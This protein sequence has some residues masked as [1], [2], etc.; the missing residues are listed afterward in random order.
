MRRRRLRRISVF[1][2]TAAL[3]FTTLEQALWTGSDSVAWGP[4]DVQAGGGRVVSVWGR[5]GGGGAHTQMRTHI[6]DRRAHARTPAH[7]FNGNRNFVPERECVARQYNARRLQYKC[8]CTPT[9][10]VEN[11]RARQALVQVGA[12]RTTAGW[13]RVR[14]SHST[15]Q[16]P[17]AGDCVIA[18]VLTRTRT[19][20]HTCTHVCSRE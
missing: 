2:K 14:D 16:L 6:H 4:K 11:I 1:L 9:H 18:P 13:W 7:S 19:C 3:T 17:A 10:S 20:A 5:V 15:A 12:C 8:R